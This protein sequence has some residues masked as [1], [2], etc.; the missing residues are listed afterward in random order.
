MVERPADNIK[1][2]GKRT[3]EKV[4]ENS[5]RPTAQRRK[6]KS[7]QRMKSG[8]PAVTTKRKVKFVEKNILPSKMEVTHGTQLTIWPQEK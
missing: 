8:I 6:K 4:P 3:T 2:M 5:K 1:K 7:I